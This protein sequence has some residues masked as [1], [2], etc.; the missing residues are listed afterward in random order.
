M[1]YSEYY[2]IEEKAT[3]LTL[4]DTKINKIGTIASEKWTWREPVKG[5]PRMF[6]SVSTAR[7]ALGS[8]CRGKLYLKNKNHNQTRPLGALVALSGSER[9]KSDYAVIKVALTSMD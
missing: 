6:K 3:G 5:Y 8:Y 7:R 2:I 1:H 4:P 9:N